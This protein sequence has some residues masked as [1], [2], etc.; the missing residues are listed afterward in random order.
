MGKF[1]AR[2]DVRANFSGS[3]NI[4]LKRKIQLPGGRKLSKRHLI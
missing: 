4:D 2:S 3:Q 1:S